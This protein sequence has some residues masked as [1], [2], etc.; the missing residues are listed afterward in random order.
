MGSLV[1]VI[2]G[3]WIQSMP[4][5]PRFL[6]IYFLFFI[7]LDKKKKLTPDTIK[8]YRSA[9]SHTFRSMGNT[10]IGDSPAVADLLKSFTLQ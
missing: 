7:H 4:W 3:V 9:I 5:Y 1:G 6:F 2:Q 10:D 8:G